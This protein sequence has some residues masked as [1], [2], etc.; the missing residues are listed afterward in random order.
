MSVGIPW[1]ALG[2]ATNEGSH[3][4]NVNGHQG[5]RSLCRTHWEPSVLILSTKFWMFV[6]GAPLATYIVQGCS[7]IGTVEGWPNPDLV[8]SG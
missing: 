4:V 3:P 7:A 1:T 5:L 8:L 2:S 6:D